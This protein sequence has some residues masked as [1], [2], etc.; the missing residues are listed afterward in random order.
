MI[1]FEHES[2]LPQ[3]YDLEK[4]YMEVTEAISIGYHYYQKTG[5]IEFVCEGFTDGIQKI[6]DAVKRFIAKV[7]EFFKRLFMR[8]NSNF[9]EYEKLAK[10][11]QDDVI[12]NWKN[13]FDIDGYVFTNIEQIPTVLP[14]SSILSLEYDVITR[15]SKASTEEIQNLCNKITSENIYSTLQHRAL[16]ID[17]SVAIGDFKKYCFRFYRNGQDSTSKVVCNKDTLADIVSKAHS[18]KNIKK[19]TLDK[20]AMVDKTL[21]KLESIFTD[22][23]SDI[24]KGINQTVDIYVYDRVNNSE[25]HRTIAESDFDKLMALSSAL[26]KLTIKVS[27]IMTTAYGEKVASLEDYIRQST[28]I[29]RKAIQVN[30]GGLSE[31]ILV[32]DKYN[33]YPQCPNQSWAGVFEGVNL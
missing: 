27:T 5:N 4:S 23:I 18:I 1:I 15:F 7:K 20:K 13:D 10:T 29:M 33:S 3:I 2:L 28:E 17:D 21:H 9:M 12:P 22:S 16:E 8:I 14:V 31:S 25:E 6:I 30:T 26:Q 24:S 11:C 19:A 32:F